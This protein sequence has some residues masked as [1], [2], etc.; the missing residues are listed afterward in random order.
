MVVPRSPDTALRPAT[1]CIR[2]LS[3]TRSSSCWMR[4]V[5]TPQLVLPPRLSLERRGRVSTEGE[6]VA[7]AATAATTFSLEMLSVPAMYLASHSPSFTLRHVTEYM[8]KYLTERWFSFTTFTERV[9][10]RNV[11]E[12]MP[13]RL[14]SP[15]FT[16][17]V[18]C[19]AL[20]DALRFLC[21]T[22]CDSLHSLIIVSPK[23]KR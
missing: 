20:R 16:S 7:F 15:P 10:V 13:V 11:K 6:M 2:S 21:V 4:R 18:V 5:L 22:P 8:M 17:L 14:V 1:R 12:K 23:K 3:R 19:V 9:L